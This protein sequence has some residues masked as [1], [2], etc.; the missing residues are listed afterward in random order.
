M[1]FN[2]GAEIIQWEKDSLFN[3]PCRENDIHMQKNEVWSLPYATVKKWI[4]DLKL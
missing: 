2:N 4:Q 1:I 3:K